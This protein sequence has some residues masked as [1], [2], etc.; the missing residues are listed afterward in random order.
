MT[1]AYDPFATGPFPVGNRT[2]QVQD[3]TYEIWSPE[4]TQPEAHALILYSH[5]SGGN[6]LAA[7]YLC[8]H[9]C[10]HGYVV[11]ALDH[12]PGVNNRV[13]ELRFL[14]EQ[15][16]TSRT[17]IGLVGHSLGGWTVLATPDAEPSIKAV[18][19]LA[20]GG[21]SNPRP[22][23]L[24][25]P[26]VF[27]WDRDVPTL[28]LVAEN[29][30][31]LPLD[32]MYEIFERMPATKRMV[33]LRRADHMHFMDNVEEV[34]EAARTM[35]LTGDLA[36]IPKEMRPIAELCSGE[37]SHLFVRGLTLSHMDAVLKEM[38]GARRFLAGDIQGEL[39]VRGVEAM[40]A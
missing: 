26:L 17:Q 34:H 7:T 10:S 9:L 37:Q 4:G 6:R 22:G 24:R 8:K 29:D 21:N 25:M 14:L 38:E 3:R 2:V 30:V 40:V 18:V 12:S 35:T 33:I 36:W 15:V 5:H 16:K 39:A 32:G 23:I 11:A 20:P 27:H 28:M 19:A 1:G 31:C 13:S